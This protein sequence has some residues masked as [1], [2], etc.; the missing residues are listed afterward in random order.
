MKKFLFFS[1]LILGFLSFGIVKADFSCERN[2]AGETIYNQDPF[3]YSCIEI[4]VPEENCGGLECVY[5]NAFFTGLTE[6]HLC[7]DPI[8]IDTSISVNWE[9]YLAFTSYVDTGNDIRVELSE[10]NAVDVNSCFTSEN[11]T[12][13]DGSIVNG[14]EVVSGSFGGFP[15]GAILPISTSFSTGALAY[16]GNVFSGLSPILLILLGVPLAFWVIT[17]AMDLIIGKKTH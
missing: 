9:D 4:F 14:F 15:Y 2:P 8:L 7:S 6:I 11:K 3:N 1:L 5:M 12:F 10:T 16:V 17:G 13:L